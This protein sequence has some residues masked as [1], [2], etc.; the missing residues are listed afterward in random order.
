VVRALREAGPH[1]YVIT[2]TTQEAYLAQVASYRAGWGPQF[3]EHLG[4]AAGVR[5]VFANRDAVV[6]T[7]N[8]PRGTPTPDLTVPTG[9]SEQHSTPWTP[10]GIVVLALLLLVLLTREYIRVAVPAAGRLIRPLTW[11]SLPMIVLLLAVVVERF[12]LMS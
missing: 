12:I 11:V 3:R 9:V 7:L 1:T 2:T 5:T 4:A 10:V 6:Y 8:W